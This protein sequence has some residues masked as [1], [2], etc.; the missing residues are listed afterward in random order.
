MFYNKAWIKS[1]CQLLTIRGNH[2]SNHCESNFLILK[3]TI[4][5]R[6]KNYNVTGLI[7]C[8]IINFNNNFKNK[9]LRIASGSS[10][11][12]IVYNFQDYRRKSEIGCNVDK[13]KEAEFIR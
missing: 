7:D 8:L 9:L 1:L 10:D 13:E 4:L 11:W 12:S 5:Q 2:T 3:D 6:V